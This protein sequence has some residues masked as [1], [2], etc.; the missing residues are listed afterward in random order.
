MGA[1]RH[2]LSVLSY[3]RADLACSENTRTQVLDL[4]FVP[5][6]VTSEGLVMARPSF[7][8]RSGYAA[9]E[10][11]TT[12]VVGANGGPSES[13]PA[14]EAPFAA[15]EAEPQGSGGNPAPVFIP[16]RLG[17]ERLAKALELELDA[18]NE[19]VLESLAAAIR[20]ELHERFMRDAR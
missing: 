16:T 1:S 6:E 15:V 8:S 5:L 2:H 3:S 4:R 11:S 9:H 7:A 13:A 14:A 12:P 17:L 10:E 20:A 18:L 19:P